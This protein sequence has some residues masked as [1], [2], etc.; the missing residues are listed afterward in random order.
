VH[1]VKLFATE[2]PEE[3]KL[4]MPEHLNSSIE[5]TL[6]ATNPEQ[7]PIFFILSRPRTGSTLLRTLFDAHPH[8]QI[9][10]ECQFI[11]NL[12]P[13]YGR[14][15]HWTPLLFGEL[16]NDLQEQFL[17]NT[18]NIEPVQ[19]LTFL[20]QFQGQ[21]SYGTICKAI[22]LQYQS[23]YYKSGITL[24]GDKN[25]GYALYTKLLSEIFPEA[26]FI[27][28]TR[29]YRDNHVSLSRVEFELPIVAL[30]VFK[31][32]YF[33]KTIT[34]ASKQHPDSFFTLRYEDLAENPEGML[35][36]VCNFLGISF[37]P[38]M[39]TFYQR[40]KA[41]EA[42]YDAKKLNKIHAS[43][44]H[45]VNTSNIGY[46]KK[47]LSTK[48]VKIADYTIGEYAAKAGYERQYAGFSLFIWLAAQPGINLAR[49]IYATTW[50]VN[51]FPYKQRQYILSELPFMLGS[52]W[53][54][55]FQRSAA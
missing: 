11:V 33:Y 40:K 8:V 26:K 3:C 13:K 45:P 49:A 10:P 46:W 12:H 52:F 35:N 37:N 41:V 4:T 38:E 6:P 14:I 19:L 7:L 55:H 24:I 21:Q 16:V 25:P 54:K 17:F 22:Y 42:L 1:L 34:K 2:L 27:H 20:Q 23:L 44:M 15:T 48:Q 5:K 29:D 43:L 39:L 53:K 47:N 9:P 36:E 50:L 18:W 31:W 28:L 32:K 51:R 30:T